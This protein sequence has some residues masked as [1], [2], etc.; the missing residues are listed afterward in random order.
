MTCSATTSDTIGR[1]RGHVDAFDA[2][3]ISAASGTQVSDLL[4][5]VT[6]MQSWLSAAQ[7]LLITRADVLAK[8]APR[9][10]RPGPRSG[11]APDDDSDGPESDT[12]P[13]SEDESATEPE[14]EAES[15]GRS[16]QDRLTGEANLSEAEARRK[17]SRADLLKQLPAFHAALVA[18]RVT[19]EHVDAIVDLLAKMILR[20]RHEFIQLANNSSLEEIAAQHTVEEFT[21]T[22]Q[23][24]LS[25]MREETPDQRLVRQRLLSFLNIWDNK[26]GMTVINAEL[27]PELGNRFRELIE[28]DLRTLWAANRDKTFP[29]PDG[30]R[31]KHGWLRAQA[32]LLRL[33]GTTPTTSNIPAGE[34]PA[35]ADRPGRTG[36]PTPAGAPQPTNNPDNVGEPGDDGSGSTV[37]AAPAIGVTLGP[38]AELVLFADFHKLTSQ[39]SAIGG[40]PVGWFGDGTPVGAATIRR[41]ACDAHVLPMIFKPDGEPLDNARRSRTANRVQRRALQKMYGGCM[42]CRT[43]FNWCQ[44]HHFWHWLDLGPSQLWNLGPLCTTHH[45][46]IHDNAHQITRNADQT[47]NLQTAT[48]LVVATTTVPHPQPP[49]ELAISNNHQPPHRTKPGRS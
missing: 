9:P 48:G 26:D 42:F 43:P 12:E 11:P 24:L 18:N 49:A 27:D 34:T 44:M 13:D 2:V 5:R 19:G 23:T 32:L 41:L 3:D 10:P 16:V 29:I 30:V 46:Q 25:G 6:G 21:A 47:L 39:L 8:S 33:T 17:R 28:T 40:E 22:L 4:G 14:G 37:P 36:Y 38:P 20:E 7:A 1:I 35:G 15:D 45:H 31:N